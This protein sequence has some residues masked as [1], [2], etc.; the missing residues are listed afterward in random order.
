MFNQIPKFLYTF[1]INITINIQIKILFSL[2]KG[3]ANFPS[4]KFLHSKHCLK[5]IR[6]KY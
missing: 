3:R 5:K 4:I 1:Q 6:N 2:L